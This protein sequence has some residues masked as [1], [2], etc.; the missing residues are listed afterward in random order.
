MFPSP[1]TGSL[2]L[3]PPRGPETRPCSLYCLVALAPAWWAGLLLTHLLPRPHSL[4]CL[5]GRL[6]KTPVPLCWKQPLYISCKGH[7]EFLPQ[8]AHTN[9]PAFPA[10]SKAELLALPRMPCLLP[11]CYPLILEGL[12]SLYFSLVYPG[13]SQTSLL[14]ACLPHF[15]VCPLLFSMSSALSGHSSHSSTHFYARVCPQYLTVISSRAAAL[16][17]CCLFRPHFLSSYVASHTVW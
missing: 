5:W 1:G 9:L 2:C 7:F 15:I 6:P 16:S 12:R 11:S 4:C 13:A 3:H 14:Q 8:V 10:A 17:T